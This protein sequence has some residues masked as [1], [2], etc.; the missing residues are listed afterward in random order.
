LTLADVAV[1]NTGTFDGIYWF[2]DEDQFGG[3]LDPDT[4]VVAG[5]NYYAFQGMGN[6]AVALEVTVEIEPIIPAPDG[7]TDQNFCYE[8]IWTLNDVEV[9]NNNGYTDIYWF[10]DTLCNGGQQIDSNTVI[11]DGDIFYAIQGINACCPGTLEVHIHIAQPHPAPTGPSD[12]YFYDGEDLIL[13]EA[14][15]YNTAGFDGIF[16]FTDAEQISE[17]VD[18]DTIVEDGDVYFAFQAICT[19]DCQLALPL[20]ITFHKVLA[21]DEYSDTFSFFP[22]PIKN[23]LVISLNRVYSSLDMLVSDSKGNIVYEN[24]NFRLLDNEYRI[25]MT[26]YT[27]GVYFLTINTPVSVKTF[28]FIKQ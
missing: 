18:Y 10:D 7:E 24:K 5:V 8:Q 3:P 14:E 1:F 21:V 28:K 16:W 26:N 15:V 19:C 25:D 27:S 20:Q 2:T 13:G 9:T 4:I 17:S 12:Q 6:C 11:N 22:N 23:E